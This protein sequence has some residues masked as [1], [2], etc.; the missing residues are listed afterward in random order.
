MKII[1]GC[2]LAYIVLVISSAST[3]M[4]LWEPYKGTEHE[5]TWSK[6][7]KNFGVGYLLVAAFFTT[8]YFAC[9]L[10]FT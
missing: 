2:V 1:I 9:S 8:L 4:W 5:E 10:I 3:M 7:L 6:S